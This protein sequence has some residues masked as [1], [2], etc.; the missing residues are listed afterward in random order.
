MRFTWSLILAINSF[1]LAPIT[2]ILLIFSIGYFIYTGS[3]VEL[4]LSLGLCILITISQV[5]LGILAD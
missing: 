5:V 4:L 3:W 1:L 2:F